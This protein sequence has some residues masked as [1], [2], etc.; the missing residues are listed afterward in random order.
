MAPRRRASTRDSGTEEAEALIV[1]KGLLAQ[2]T[3]ESRRLLGLT[4]SLLIY[5]SVAT[6]W[7]YLSATD[8]DVKCRYAILE[9]VNNETVTALPMMTPTKAVTTREITTKKRFT[10]TTESPVATSEPC[11]DTWIH[12]EQFSKCYKPFLKPANYLEAEAKCR[13]LGAEI[14]S[15]DSWE[16]NQAVTHLK[17]NG[18]LLRNSYRS[19]PLAPRFHKLTRE[20]YGPHGEKVHFTNFYDDGKVR[21]PNGIYANENC[22][23]LW[24]ADHN[25]PTTEEAFSMRWN[26]IPC[27]WRRDAFICEKK[28]TSIVDQ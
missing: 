12:M 16:E 3:T 14:L 24:R 5:N 19:I 11:P 18:K 10:T 26:D 6:F 15:I 9:F 25:E 23:E 2:R 27:E 7:V 20:L 4:L 28:V 13:A 21:E 8:A 17:V 1:R 22:L